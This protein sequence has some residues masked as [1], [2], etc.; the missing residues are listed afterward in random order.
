[1]RSTC[2]KR[3][4]RLVSDQLSILLGSTSL[5]QRFPGLYASTL[6][7]RR[8]SLERNRWQLSRVIFTG[9]P[10]PSWPFD[11]K[12]VL[13]Y[14]YFSQAQIVRACELHTHIASLRAAHAI[15]AEGFGI[16]V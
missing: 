10:G 4:C 16:V 6:G 2:A 11:S 8:T 3:C 14:L 15:V 7:Q 1:V 5:R 9:K 13:E 12:F